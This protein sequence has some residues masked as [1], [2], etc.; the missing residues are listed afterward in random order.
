LIDLN[1]QH[2]SAHQKAPS[3][4]PGAYRVIQRQSHG[5]RP[6]PTPGISLLGKAK[7]PERGSV[8]DASHTCGLLLDL[9]CPELGLQ[10]TSDIAVTP[11]LAALAA[12]QR[13]ALRQLVDTGL[14]RKAPPTNAKVLL[15]KLHNRTYNFLYNLVNDFVCDLVS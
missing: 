12:V 13:W 2:N 11:L 4:E 8:A 6:C 15:C 9:P 3:D 5:L 7:L 10:F 14:Y 1:E